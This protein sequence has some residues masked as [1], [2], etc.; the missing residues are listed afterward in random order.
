MASGIHY[1]LTPMDTMREICRVD[2]IHRLSGGVNLKLDNLSGVEYLMPG[3]PISVNLTDRTATAVINVLVVETASSATEIKIAKGSL[4]YVGMHVGTGS[5][6]ATISDIDKSNEAYDKVTV[7]T[8]ISVNKG[9]VLFEATAVGGTKPKATATHLNYA[10][11]KVESG[12]TVTPVY[13]AFE[14]QE[15]HL[16]QPISV[17]DKETL[18]PRFYFIP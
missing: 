12:A 18:T 17:K 9:D 4:A 10:R 16:Y 7:G 5:A 1:D 3:A 2:T 11:T 13:G 15:S 6:G 14:V 8:A